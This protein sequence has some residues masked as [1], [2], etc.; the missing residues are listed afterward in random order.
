MLC[1]S[2][3][4]Q[5]VAVQSFRGGGGQVAELGSVLVVLGRLAVVAHVA[6]VSRGGV[7]KR[8]RPPAGRLQLS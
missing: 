2:P 6:G 1:S 7:T 5:I 4:E 3:S 8:C